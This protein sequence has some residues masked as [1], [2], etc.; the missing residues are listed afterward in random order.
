M[1][2]F[3]AMFGGNGSS[4]EPNESVLAEW[5]KCVSNPDFKSQTHKKH[6]FTI[7]YLLCYWVSQECWDFPDT[8][9]VFQ[10][11]GIGHYNTALVTMRRS[12]ITYSKEDQQGVS[13]KYYLIELTV[14]S[15]A[16]V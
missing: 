16:Q 15:F 1:E 14:I 11:R 9:W 2:Q 13:S 4:S 6:I 12:P 7:S 5:N 3:K 10:Y 8:G